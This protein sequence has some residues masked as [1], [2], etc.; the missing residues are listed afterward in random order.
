M[1]NIK[2]TESDMHYV[3]RVWTKVQE[4]LEYI[5]G[6]YNKDGDRGLNRSEVAEFFKKNNVK[7]P[8]IQTQLIFK[9]LDGYR[10]RFDQ[11]G[12]KKITYDEMIEDFNTF[13]KFETDLHKNDAYNTADFLFNKIDTDK[14]GVLTVADLTK[15]C[16]PLP[17]PEQ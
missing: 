12:D 14:D 7:F 10:G 9:Y 15:Y 13:F 3:H 16:G 1:N 11:N 5:L 17:N 2:L 4:E 8:N 6:K